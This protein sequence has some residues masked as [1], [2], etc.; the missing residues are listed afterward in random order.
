MVFLLKLTICWGFF[1]LLYV[2]LLRRETFFQANRVYLIS[3]MLAGIVSAAVSDWLLGHAQEDALLVITLPAVSAGFQ[4]AAEVS[5]QLERADYLWILY[6]AGVGLYV[7]P[8]DMGHYP[9][10]TNGCTRQLGIAAR[11]LQADQ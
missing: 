2:L 8:H 7:A 3:T 1:A 4:Q 5:Q 9:T 10:G 6:F 11:W